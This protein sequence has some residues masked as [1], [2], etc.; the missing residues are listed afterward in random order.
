MIVAGDVAGLRAWTREQRAA[1]RRVG[2]VPTMGFLHEGHLALVDEA[3]RRSDLVALSI[4]VNPLQFAPTEDLDR[5]PRD[6]AR[7]QAL[8]AARG[9]DLLFVPDAATMY[10]P[11]TDTRVVPGEAAERWEGAARPGHFA[12]VLTVVAKLFNLVQPDVAC[13]GQK[14]IQQLTL[15]RAMVEDVDWPIEMSQTSAGET[16]PL[17]PATS[18]ARPSSTLRR[19]RLPTIARCAAARPS[20]NVTAGESA[21]TWPT[22]RSS[23]LGPRTMW[24]GTALADICPPDGCIYMYGQF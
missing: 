10:P 4:F 5:Y 22:A 12:G 17:L 11:G 16:S 3:R 6:L 13:F 9:V 15:V 1:G 24:V 2:F 8:A 23:K 21:K 14:D 20:V 18:A 7:D 19:S